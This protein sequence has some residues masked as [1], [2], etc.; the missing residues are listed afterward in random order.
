[1]KIPLG[2]VLMSMDVVS[3]FTNIPLELVISIIEDKWQLI[4]PCC[5]FNKNSFINTIKFIFKCYYFCFDGK[6]Y[7]QTFGTPMGS[8]LSPIIAMIT[9]DVL[10]DNVLPTFFLFFD[11]DIIQM[12]VDFSN[13]YANVHNREGN[14]SPNEIRCFIGILLYSG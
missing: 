12:L 3:L 2:Y 9:M 5:N 13:L 7:Q 10:F 11:D 8:P 6:F 1:M 14:I 4:E